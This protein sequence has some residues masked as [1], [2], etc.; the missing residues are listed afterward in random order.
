MMAS[1]MYGRE[2]Y[3]EASFKAL[4]S[5]EGRAVY[6]AKNANGELTRELHE[7]LNK[8]T[9]TDAGRR[10]FSALM[11]LQRHGIEIPGP[12]YNFAQCQ[13]RL[14]GAVEEMNTL[15]N[16]LK[17]SISRLALAPIEVP[18]ISEDAQSVSGGVKDAIGA[19]RRFLNREGAQSYSSLSRDLEAHFGTSK[20]GGR[21]DFDT[22]RLPTLLD[23]LKTAFADRSTFDN[24]L[25]PFVERL[26]EAKTFNLRDVW[27]VEFYGEKGN[28]LREKLA[29]F[30]VARDGGDT[31]LEASAAA[32]LANAFVMAVRTYNMAMSM[33]IPDRAEEPDEGAF[34]YAIANVVNSNLQPALKSLGAKAVPIYFDMRAAKAKEQAA[35][36]RTGG[37]LQ[38]VQAYV[39]AFAGGAVSAEAVRA[40]ARISQ[41]FQHPL[42]MPGMNGSAGSLKSNANRA[43]FLTTLR[44]N[45]D[46]LENELRAEGLLTDET[47][48]EMK[49]H[50]ARIAMQFFADRVGG[51]ADAVR[52]LSSSAYANLYDEAY[53]QEVNSP[54]L[55]VRDALVHFRFPVT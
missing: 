18:E 10:I 9:T 36:E 15:M 8:G 41:D 14:G 44:F 5:E 40:I 17:L 4:I 31:A 49:T 28:M 6:D 43:L 3:F 27:N 33:H 12:I 32:E 45:L 42:E 51:I 47:T 26:C 13:M 52:K 35:A 50:F 53:A 23:E 16:E 22:M 2:K 29:A 34:V 19:L 21:S 11:C 20:M 24:F 37:S 25:L 39:N 48:S 38:R 54:K 7:I 46:H 1:A 30:K 55:L